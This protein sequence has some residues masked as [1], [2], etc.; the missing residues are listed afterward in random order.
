[1]LSLTRLP[2]LKLLR[3]TGPVR[4]NGTD[5]KIPGV[6][7]EGKKLGI[8]FTC[9]KCTTRSAKQ[10]SEQSFKHGVVIVRCPGCQAHHLIADRLGMF[11][12]GSWD[13]EQ[14]LSEG[15][16]KRVSNEDVFELTAEDLLGKKKPLK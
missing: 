4:F 5:I 3:I 13:V 15:N 8:V 16:F 2:H 1:M 7:S 12:D 11:Q 6:V 14:A 9:D 10:I